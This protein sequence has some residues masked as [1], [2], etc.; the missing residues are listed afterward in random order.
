LWGKLNAFLC[1][2]KDKKGEKSKMNRIKNAF[3]ARIRN[4]SKPKK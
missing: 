2:L 1:N 3:L 4:I